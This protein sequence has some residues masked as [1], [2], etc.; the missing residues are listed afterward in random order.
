MTAPPISPYLVLRPASLSD[1]P[2]IETPTL[3]MAA[4]AGREA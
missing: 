4:P 3:M 1:L 2:A